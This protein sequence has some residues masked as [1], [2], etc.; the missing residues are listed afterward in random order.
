VQQ[1]LGVLVGVNLLLHRQLLLEAAA[2]A[3]VWLQ[4]QVLVPHIEWLMQAQPGGC[5]RGVP[6]E[7]GGAC[8]S[9]FRSGAAV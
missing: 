5:G 4:Q 7:N 3:G 2:A 8:R 6:E 9:V 1:L